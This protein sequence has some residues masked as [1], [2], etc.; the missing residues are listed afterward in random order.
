MMSKE[1]YHVTCDGKVRGRVFQILDGV[2]DD[3]EQMPDGYVYNVEI[4]IESKPDGASGGD[5]A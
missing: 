3:V 5:G 1:Q 4:K 2:M